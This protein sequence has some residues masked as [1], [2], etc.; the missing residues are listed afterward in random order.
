MKSQVTKNYRSKSI[1]FWLL[2]LLSWLGT[3]G[4]LII[5]GLSNAFDLSSETATETIGSQLLDI[6]MPLIVT[7][8]IAI[9]LVI[10]VREKARNSV[11]M[12]NIILSAVLL[13]DVFLYICIV[14]FAID[15]FILMPL[16][17]RFKLRYNINAEIDKR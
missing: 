13:G 1:T 2:S 17:K 8:G 5:Y 6:F 11:W 14:L 9:I 16:H 3:C 10:F 7:Y 12:V 4:G 15:E